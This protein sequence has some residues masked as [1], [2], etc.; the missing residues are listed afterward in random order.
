M[1]CN[2]CKKECHVQYYNKTEKRWE[3]VKCTE[4]LN[5]SQKKGTDSKKA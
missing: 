4:Y 3:C 1:I 5:S 2:K